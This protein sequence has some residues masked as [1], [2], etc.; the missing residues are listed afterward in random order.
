[1]ASILTTS[2]DILISALLDI[3][4]LHELGL[5]SYSTITDCTFS[6][7]YVYSSRSNVIILFLNCISMI[8]RVLYKVE[9]SA[10]FFWCSKFTIYHINKS[11]KIEKCFMISAINACHQTNNWDHIWG[12]SP[13]KTYMLICFASSQKAIIL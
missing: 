10:Y 3:T 6:M 13:Y 11:T 9:G 5:V 7:H 12:F 1:M 4:F 2:P 8:S